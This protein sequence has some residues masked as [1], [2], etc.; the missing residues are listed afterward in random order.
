MKKKPTRKKSMKHSV[1]NSKK[2]STTKKK[3]E[4]KGGLP[5]LSTQGI[6]LDYIQCGYKISKV[7]RLRKIKWD[8]VLNHLDSK[9]GREILEAQRRAVRLRFEGVLDKVISKVEEVLD[10]P[11][12]NSTTEKAIK[13]VL[14][15]TG[16]SVGA[17]QATAQMASIYKKE[18]SDKHD[19]MTE[20]RKNWDKEANEMLENAKKRDSQAHVQ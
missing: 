9:A 2:K 7:A 15:L 13:V 3:K 4:S 1:S 11:V 8:V 14:D 17:R 10:K 6:V 5:P 18:T 16:F 20:L 12:F 19:D